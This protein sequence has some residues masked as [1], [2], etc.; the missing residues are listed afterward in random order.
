MNRTLKK[1]LFSFN[2]RIMLEFESPQEDQDFSEVYIR[3]FILYIEI[4]YESL[5]DTELIITESL[6]LYL[7]NFNDYDLIADNIT[8][9]NAGASGLNDLDDDSCLLEENENIDFFI[10]KYAKAKVRI[11]KNNF[12]N[13]IKIVIYEEK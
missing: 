6:D 11:L 3:S 2:N 5:I 12:K 10:L 7:S 13:K 8:L 9:I 4:G 1:E